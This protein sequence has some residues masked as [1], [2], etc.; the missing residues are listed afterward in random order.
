MEEM[1]RKIK[2]L[3]NQFHYPNIFTVF[4]DYAEE[5]IDYEVF[6]TRLL[7]I[8]A[9]LRDKIKISEDDIKTLF[10]VLME[11]EEGEG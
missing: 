7:M 8:V 11:L 1:D 2:L 6:K 4:D 3:T 9:D 5:M 10:S